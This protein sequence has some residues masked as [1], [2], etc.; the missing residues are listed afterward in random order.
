[1][2]KSIMEEKGK[3]DKNPW[4][5]HPLYIAYKSFHDGK[6]VA[7]GRIVG[8]VIALIVVIVCLLFFW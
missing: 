6:N 2:T 1:M 5:F 3:E 8:L 4:R 7:M